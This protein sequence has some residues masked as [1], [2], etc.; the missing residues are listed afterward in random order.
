MQLAIC[1]L[2]IRRKINDQ[3]TKQISQYIEEPRSKTR[4]QNCARYL[5][6]LAFRVSHC[7]SW[8]HRARRWSTSI[9]A[10]RFAPSLRHF[11]FSPLSLSLSL[12]LSTSPFLPLPLFLPSSLSE[13]EKVHRPDTRYSR[14]FTHLATLFYLVRRNICALA[15]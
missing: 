4:S 2:S 12:L 6:A 14:F 15:L 7:K 3:A 10:D 13:E 5:L 11:T 1:K 8:F 9:F